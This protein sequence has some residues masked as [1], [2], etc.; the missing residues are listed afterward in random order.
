MDDAVGHEQARW[1]RPDAVRRAHAP[2]PS[3]LRVACAGHAHPGPTRSRAVRREV[4][5][6]IREEAEG[7]L[8]TQY[9]SIAK[10]AVVMAVVLFMLYL[11]KPPAHAEISTFSTALLT[12]ATFSTGALMSAAAGYIGMYI[13]VRANV[14][15][16]AAATRSYQEA[17]DV[18]LRGGAVCGLLVVGLCVGGITTLFVLLRA[19]YPNLP[20]PTTASLLVGFGFGASLVALFAQ[21][22]G[23]IYTKAADVGA[24]LVGK[25]E[26]GIP[27]D[28]P[29]NPAV[30]ADLVGDNVGD[31]AGRGADLFE[32]ISAEIIGAMLL[33]GSLAGARHLPEDVATNYML[34]PL[35]IHALDLVVSS[36]GVMSARV[37][38]G[39]NIDVADALEASKRG[40]L[41]RDAD[42][43][44]KAIANMEDPLAVLKRG[45]RTSL[46]L[47]C[48]GVVVCSRTLLHTDAYPDAWWKFA[49]CGLLGLCNAIVFLQLAQ[50]Y[51]DYAYEPVRRIAS[52]ST[53]GHGTNIIAGVAVG[54]ESTCL[55][56]VCVGIS[57]LA[58]YHMGDSAIPGG[59]LFGTSV[60]TMGM[61]SSAVYVLA[62][63]TFGPIADNAGGIVEMSDQPEIVRDI[64]DRLDAVGNV[65]KAATKG[66]SIGS[67]GLAC[68]LLFSAFM[69]LVSEQSGRR[70]AHVDFAIPEVFVGGLLGGMLVFTFSG[71]AMKAVG[72]CASQVVVE[73]RRQFHDRPGIMDGSQKPDYSAC[74]SIVA[75]AAL[76]E[77][78]KP[79]LLALAFPIAVG[80]V[81]KY[82]GSWQSKP[83]LGPQVLAGMLMSSTMTGILLSLFLNNAGGAW[84][85]AKKYIETVRHQ[86]KPTK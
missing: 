79:G 76:K 43:A 65:T 51:T 32:S 6:A 75:A 17:I 72:I 31:C 16:A 70:F 55:P 26:A 85:N 49:G 69:E 42:G 13:S 62:M 56:V 23:G 25:V 19:M 66:Y 11:T 64:T 7:F 45:Y 5:D 29:R 54:M 24:D 15:T 28:D 46:M 53:T 80:V 8:R 50:Y 73:V 20:V 86:P 68:F 78:R 14:R 77:M 36:V 21:L 47:S 41:S 38:P 4:A 27:E 81:F 60:A 84:D 33:G 35:L 2:A 83:L 74:V 59:G 34:F 10:Y 39:A 12:T 82:L 52:A 9:S 37:K 63:D 67:A 1:Q 57:I 22:G 71:F 18:A 30:I 3:P 48:I 61:L 44:S 58:A 40:L